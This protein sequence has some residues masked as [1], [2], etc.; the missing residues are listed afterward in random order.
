MDEVEMLGALEAG[1]A[2]RGVE[3]DAYISVDSYG[4]HN[5]HLSRIMVEKAYRRQGLGTQAMQ[6][7]VDLADQYGL[8]MSLSPSTDF[9]GTSVDR[10]KRFYRRFGFVSNKGRHK[11]FTLSDSMYRLPKIH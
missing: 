1:W 4:R 9:G 3:I 5:L 8:L 6:D 7:L 2:S 10:L 11:D